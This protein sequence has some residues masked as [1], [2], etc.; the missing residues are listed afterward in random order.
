MTTRINNIEINNKISV[1]EVQTETQ[2]KFD[3]V[4][5]NITGRIERVHNEMKT[6]KLRQTCKRKLI[7]TRE[8]LEMIKWGLAKLHN[9]PITEPRDCLLYTSYIYI[10]TQ[11]NKV[12]VPDVI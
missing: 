1:T 6:M 9:I 12:E 5:I 3:E 7:N 2:E 11:R 8:G 4:P 10:Y